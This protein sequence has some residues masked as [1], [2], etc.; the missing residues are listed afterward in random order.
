M[1]DT[2]MRAFFDIPI[3]SPTGQ[4][5][6]GIKQY[7]DSVI[8]VEEN[9][10]YI[11]EHPD[12]DMFLRIV[13][14]EIVDNYMIKMVGSSWI[15]YDNDG[16]LDF[17]ACGERINNFL[18]ANQ[19]DGTFLK[20]NSG[21]IVNEASWSLGNAWGDYNND[22]YVDLF[23]TNYGEKNF[24]YQNEGNGTFT[25]I[26]EGEI[27]NDISYSRGA[28]WGDYNNDG[29]LD[30]FVANGEGEN[31]FLYKNNRNGKFK[32]I[33]QGEIVNDG[34][35]SHCGNWCDYDNDGY[36]DLF[37]ANLQENNFLYH[38]NRDSTFTRIKAGELVNDPN[39]SLACCWGDYDNDGYFDLFIANYGAENQLFCNNGDGTFTEQ[40]QNAMMN[41]DILSVGCMWGDF[42]NNGKSDLVIANFMDG[43][44]NLYLNNG[45]N[46]F[47]RKS[48]GYFQIDRAYSAGCVCGDYDNDG[49][50]DLMINTYGNLDNNILY[51]NKGN[52]NNWINIKCIGVLSNKSAIGTKVK[53]RAVIKGHAVWQ[54]QQISGFTGRFDQNSLNAEFGLGDATIIDT[55]RI[56]W[57]SG[58]IQMLTQQDVNQFLEIHEEQS[59]SSK[60]NF[61]T[62]GAME[63]GVTNLNNNI[64]YAPVSGDK[65]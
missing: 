58:I 12:D 41:D 24:L 60:F 54:M 28:C 40:A 31:N 62:S 46:S 14:G 27:V 22:G 59:I 56:E 8:L 52:S 11:Y 6:L 61:K 23:V 4:W 44:N 30:L 53:V 17:Y 42:D 57:P 26:T 15:D 9:A 63:A 39:S 21:D 37:V 33:S 10:V 36:I 5:D 18:F 43:K 19:G 1:T 55:I 2:T 51:M 47:T 48:D 16:D 65:I 35:I 49:D 25:K 3:Q 20:I 13:E 34:G 7:A 64:F 45:Q 29:Y 32:K 50:L 38:N